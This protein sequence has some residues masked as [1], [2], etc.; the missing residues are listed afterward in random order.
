MNLI[1]KLC[2]VAIFLTSLK[3]LGV[4]RDDLMAI[5]M[6]KHNPVPADQACSG[7]G[8]GLRAIPLVYGVAI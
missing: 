4:A 1:M 5:I 3:L 2:G 7:R 8:R 6:I